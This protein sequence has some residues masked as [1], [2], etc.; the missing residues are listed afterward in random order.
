VERVFV[1]FVFYN[2]YIYITH[3]FNQT[4]VIQAFFSACGEKVCITLC[5]TENGT[6][7]SVFLQEYLGFI[8]HIKPIRINVWIIRR[9]G[10]ISHKSIT[11]SHYQLL[12]LHVF[13]TP[14]C[15]LLEHFPKHFFLQLLNPK[16]IPNYFYITEK[17]VTYVINTKLHTCFDTARQIALIRYEEGFNSTFGLVVSFLLTNMQ[18]VVVYQNTC[19]VFYI[20]IYQ[21]ADF[22]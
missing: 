16:C 2:I 19:V 6:T 7:F 9:F 17:H 5:D 8:R 1:V 4:A 22:V 21:S 20:Y 15:C 14:F 11:T 10:T 3:V 12:C 18:S 13:E